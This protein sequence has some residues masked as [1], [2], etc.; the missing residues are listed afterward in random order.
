[1]KTRAS[2][3]KNKALKVSSDEAPG[4]RSHSRQQKAWAKRLETNATQATLQ[5]GEKDK[6][7]ARRSGAGSCLSL[8]SPAVDGDPDSLGNETLAQGRKRGRGGDDQPPSEAKKAKKKEKSTLDMALSE[9]G[10]LKDAFIQASAGYTM[11]M[12]NVK[13]DKSWRWAAKCTGELE[14]KWTSMEGRV[15]DFARRFFSEDIK[16]LKK[17]LAGTILEAET[18][19]MVREMKESVAEVNM[20]LK[21]LKA[22]HCSRNKA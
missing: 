20:E 16:E 15:S 6:N 18:V 3:T 19:K 13:T 21:Q 4:C 11:L 12:Q 7:N 22:M 17:G 8:A 1:M 2:Q 14:E 10:K 9:G 5:E